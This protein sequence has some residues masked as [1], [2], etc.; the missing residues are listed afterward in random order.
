MTGAVVEE[1]EG[2]PEHPVLARDE[3]EVAVTVDVAQPQRGEARVDGRVQVAHGHV[4]EV[5]GAVVVK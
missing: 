4:R 2:H 1:Q 3:V 5:T